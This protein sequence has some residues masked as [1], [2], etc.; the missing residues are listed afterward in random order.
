MS[1]EMASFASSVHKYSQVSHSVLVLARKRKT[2]TKTI[3]KKVKVKRN[4]TRSREFGEFT[5]R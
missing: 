2:K 5:L 1:N 3:K 4:Y